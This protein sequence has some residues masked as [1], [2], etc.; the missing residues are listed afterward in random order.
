MKQTFE[1]KLTNKLSVVP[2]HN[3]EFENNQDSENFSD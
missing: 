3:T 1:Y 2:P